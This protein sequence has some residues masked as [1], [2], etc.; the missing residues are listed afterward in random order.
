M[1][2]FKW[3]GGRWVNEVLTFVRVF[4]SRLHFLQT[5]ETQPYRF[6]IESASVARKKKHRQDLNLKLTPL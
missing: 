1:T 6:S 5:K 3:I 4:H 2:A